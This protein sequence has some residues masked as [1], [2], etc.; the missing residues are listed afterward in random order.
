MQIKRMH[1]T[2]LLPYVKRNV[3]FCLNGIFVFGLYGVFSRLGN[4]VLY[5]N[6][7]GLLLHEK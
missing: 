1:D 4:Y 2:H 5:L 7:I 6:L 3:P